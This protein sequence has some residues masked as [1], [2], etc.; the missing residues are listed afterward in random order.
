M[1]GVFLKHSH[2]LTHKLCKKMAFSAAKILKILGP[3]SHGTSLGV[4]FFFS[5]FQNH[6]TNLAGSAVHQAVSVGVVFR[7]TGSAGCYQ[8]C[9]LKN[10][11]HEASWVITV[12]I[13]AGN[14]HETT[15]GG[16]LTDIEPEIEWWL[17][18]RETAKAN[19]STRAYL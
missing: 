1:C 17:T 4:C 14:V 11:G 5:V 13:T 6:I 15:S 9:Y 3:P 12:L 16:S 10:E 2:S 8:H 18:G 19:C 7:E